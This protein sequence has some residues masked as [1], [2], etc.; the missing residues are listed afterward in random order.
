VFCG[1]SGSGGEGL[2]GGGLGRGC[3]GRRRRVV[4]GRVL[5]SACLKILGLDVHVV[6]NFGW[7]MGG[8]LTDWHSFNLCV[9]VLDPRIINGEHLMEWFAGEFEKGQG[10][11]E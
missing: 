3:R 4:L 8:R 9:W 2:L 7:F 10:Q 11:E 6:E 5:V 1:R